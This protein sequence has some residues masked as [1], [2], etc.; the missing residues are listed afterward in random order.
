[1]I[2]SS[3]AGSAME[4]YDFSIYG[5]AS[6]LVFSDLFFPQVD[7]TVG[8]LATFGAYA[9]GFLARSF[10]GLFFGRL[11]DRI[12]RESVLVATILLMGVSTFL[13]GML[14]TYQTVGAWSAVLLLVLRLAQGSAPAQSRRGLRCSLP[15]SRRERNVVSTARCRSPASSS[16]SCWPAASSR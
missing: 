15:N 6:A 4:W 12:G 1:V 5:T 10:G 8:L 16:A 11:G 9:A 14:P 2:G 3:V 7:H 13:I